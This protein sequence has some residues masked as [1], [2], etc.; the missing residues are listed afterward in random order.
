MSHRRPA[1]N[2]APAPPAIRDGVASALPST[3]PLPVASESDARR[4]CVPATRRPRCQPHLV[5]LQRRAVFRSEALAVAEVQNLRV[6]RASFCWSGR[7]PG[8]AEES[9]SWPSPRGQ[10]RVIRVPRPMCTADRALPHCVRP[11]SPR[12][13]AT[14]ASET[15][16]RPRVAQPCRIGA[17]RCLRPWPA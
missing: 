9:T 7:L 1:C 15:R 3:R 14:G 16:R 4:R 11:S 13:P 8:R 10:G 5:G 12:A 2:A 6:G 17:L